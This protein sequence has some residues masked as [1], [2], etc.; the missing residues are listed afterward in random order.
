VL[1][2]LDFH[3]LLGQP[4]HGLAQHI[5]VLVGQHLAHQFLDPH[6]A[7]VGHRGA[8]LVGTEAPTILKPAM[9]D[10]PASFTSQ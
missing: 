1:G 8:P 3:Q 10:L 9:A 4:D 6:P 7:Q 5:G 2:D